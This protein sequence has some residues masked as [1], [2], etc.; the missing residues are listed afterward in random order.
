VSE[1]PS[2]LVY[3]WGA[4]LLRWEL[5]STE[6]GT[7]LRLHQSFNDWRLAS[8][9]A[10]GWHICLDVADAMMKDVPF[11]PV[12]GNQALDYGWDQLNRGYA[13]SLG[14]EPTEPP[15]E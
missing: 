6:D 12:V 8:A 2:L 3:D 11:G 14:I 9:L 1:P 4:D 5:S 7:V 15:A 10:A 13:A